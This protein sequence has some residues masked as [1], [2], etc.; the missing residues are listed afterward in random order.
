MN[1]SKV[2]FLCGLFLFID[3]AFSCFHD[4]IDGEGA[5]EICF[6]W[7]GVQAFPMKPVRPQW[8]SPCF[9]EG[10]YVFPK[11]RILLTRMILLTEGLVTDFLRYTRFIDCVCGETRDENSLSFVF[12]G[13]VEQFYDKGLIAGF[14]K[15]KN[16]S[17]M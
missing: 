3:E 8:K 17:L 6:F 7:V 14:I 16:E 13:A 5:C 2:I 1:F 9:M 4:G 12:Q 10:Q 11:R 15:K